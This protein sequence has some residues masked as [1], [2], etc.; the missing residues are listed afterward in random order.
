MIE[1][2]SSPRSRGVIKNE[3][4]K[5]CSIHRDTAA[6]SGEG[7]RYVA[8]SYQMVPGSAAGVIVLTADGLKQQCAR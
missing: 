3:L 5:R 2:Y 7:A 4:L 6:L 8:Q 1:T